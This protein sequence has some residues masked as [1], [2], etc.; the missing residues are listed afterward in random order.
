MKESD[1]Q[2]RIDCIEK[3]IQSLES[4]D[5]DSITGPSRKRLKE[6]KQMQDQKQKIT[7]K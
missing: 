5:L 7:Q 1:I 4:V 3:G 2:R 6:L